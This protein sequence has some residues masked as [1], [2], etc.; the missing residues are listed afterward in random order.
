MVDNLAISYEI[1]GHGQILVLLHGWGDRAA[2]LKNLAQALSKNYQVIVPDLPGFGASDAPP[3]AWDLSDY[4]KFVNGFLLKIKAGKSYAFIGHSNGAA[5]AIRGLG[6][7]I[8][9]AEKLVLLSSAGI[10]GDYKARN[11][12]LRLATKTGKTLTAPLPKTAKQKLKQKVYTSL[13]SDMLVA[14]NLQ[15]TF[16]KIIN[17]DVRIDA[18]K[19]QTPTMIIYG[20][21]DQA[22][23]LS[24]AK[25][26]NQ[27]IQNS[28]LEII[29]GAGHFVHLDA[30]QKVYNLT[31]EFLNV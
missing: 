2:G 26:F 24:Y 4:A 1:S 19:I 13:G 29:A 30:P 20:D 27:K 28:R 3:S 14:E 23:P 18:E 25:T 21:Q 9:T 12:A 11:Y 6:Q 17:D 31:Q 8:L 10:R 22:T 5:I 7:N 15:E 16:K